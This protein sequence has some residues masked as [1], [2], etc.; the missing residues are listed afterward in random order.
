MKKIVFILITMFSVNANAQTWAEEHYSY[1][2]FNKMMT[3]YYN[4]GLYSEATNYIDS[5]QNN[6]FLS[7]DDYFMFARIN[8]LSNNFRVTL[9]FLEQ[10]VKTGITKKGIE[11][12]Y[13]MD[14]FR[15]S[16]MN[17]LFELNYD[18]WHQDYI[19]KEQVFNEKIDN[20]YVSQI[21]KLDSVRQQIFHDYFKTKSNQKDSLI[22]S[23]KILE[24]DSLNFLILTN[25]ILEKGFPVK[26]RVGEKAFFMA[27][28]ILFMNVDG[29]QNENSKWKQIKPIIQ[30]EIKKEHLKP[31]YYAQ[32][33]EQYLFNNNQPK[34]YGTRIAYYRLLADVD[35]PQYE[36]ENPEE[37]NLRRKSVGL[38]KVEVECWAY[39]IDLPEPL[40]NIKFK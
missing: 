27:N 30:D 3:G 39:A 8:S 28:K 37:L 36:Y 18:N 19:L 11:N 35:V 38:C 14:N 21:L 1:D 6:K 40:Q 25:L 12:I 10:A 9:E 32:L 22:A 26:R 15:Q 34:C 20:D 29:L 23:N 5:L 31:F 13:D 2:T 33:Y 7:A 24:Q 17:I 16:N 4:R